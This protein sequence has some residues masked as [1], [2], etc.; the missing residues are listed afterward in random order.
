[1]Y[2]ECVRMR[3]N[4]YITNIYMYTQEECTC[5]CAMSVAYVHMY[6]NEYIHVYMKSMRAWCMRVCT[7]K[8]VCVYISRVN[9]CVWIYGPTETVICVCI[10]SWLY[11]HMYTAQLG[12][13]NIYV[14]KK[15]V[16]RMRAKG[17]VCMYVCMDVCTMSTS[18]VNTCILLTCICELGSWC[19]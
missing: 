8:C 9:T 1:M 6:N 14:R 15:I 16:I 13:H 19:A 18:I 11:I 7:Y 12:L 17:Y 3:T 5:L 4:A 10:H 2:D